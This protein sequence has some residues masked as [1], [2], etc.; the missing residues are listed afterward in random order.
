MIRGG[1]RCEQKTQ[2][3]LRHRRR[4]VATRRRQPDF[5]LAPSPPIE[6][7][8]G[9]MP[10]P[11]GPLVGPV[12]GPLVGQVAGLR[13]EPVRARL[14]NAALSRRGCRAPDGG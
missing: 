2:G 6:H 3:R 8:I 4:A 14:V 9:P 1:W 7:T 5:G 13:L 10:C 11:I 12:V